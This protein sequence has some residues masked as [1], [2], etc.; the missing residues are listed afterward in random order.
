[1]LHNYSNLSNINWLI[2]EVFT[3]SINSFKNQNYNL[4]INNEEKKTILQI[5]ILEHTTDLFAKHRR[6]VI[7]DMVGNK[8]DL[9]FCQLREEQAQL[10]WH[11]NGY[12]IFY[13][14]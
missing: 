7:Q 3:V 10:G 8:F 4:S 9:L 5:R 13:F 2:D 6:D 14:P 12:I 11:K 1:M